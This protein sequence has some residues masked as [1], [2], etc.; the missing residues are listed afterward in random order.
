ML[1]I[2]ETENTSNLDGSIKCL[3]LVTSTVLH[4]TR[5]RRRTEALGPRVNGRVC[6]ESRDVKNMTLYDI[7]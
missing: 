4:V 7:I 6:F 2:A 1:N 5:V 3:N